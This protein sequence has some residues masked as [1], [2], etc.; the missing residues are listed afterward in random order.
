MVTC[1]GKLTWF[2]EQWCIK[3]QLHVNLR[4][5]I[6]YHLKLRLNVGL[7]I[8]TARKGKLA[9][10]KLLLSRIKKKT[11]NISYFFLI[12]DLYLEKQNINISRMSNL[13]V[14][15]S[16]I[17]DDV[18]CTCSPNKILLY[19]VVHSTEKPTQKGE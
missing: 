9:C 11:L 6:I 13:K 3:H 14:H 2:D 10:L 4:H 5:L 17:H 19:K 15:W 12:S 16:P 1:Q 18:F 8:C 7:L